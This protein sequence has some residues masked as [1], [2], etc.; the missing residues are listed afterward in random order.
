MRFNVIAME[1]PDLEP[2]VELRVIKHGHKSG[3]LVDI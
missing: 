1:I 2:G 3:P